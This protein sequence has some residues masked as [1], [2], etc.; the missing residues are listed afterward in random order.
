MFACDDNAKFT[1][2]PLADTA[3]VLTNWNLG[4]TIDLA[5]TAGWGNDTDVTIQLQ[6]NLLAD[7]RITGDLAFIQKKQGEIGLSINPVPV[8]AAVWLWFDWY[9]RHSQTQDQLAV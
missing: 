9:D 6:N 7:S 4:G 8:P 1:A 2:G 5:A 3:G